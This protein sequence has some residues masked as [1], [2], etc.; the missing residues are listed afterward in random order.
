MSINGVSPG[1]AYH[2]S[3]PT[4][5]VAELATILRQARQAARETANAHTD[6]AVDCSM[7][8]AEHARDRAE[9]VRNSAYL[10]FAM[11]CGSALN[12]I[13]CAAMTGRSK[14]ANPDR[15]SSIARSSE[16][17]MGSVAKAVEA[18]DNAFG[19]G[20]QASHLEAKMEQDS[21]NEAQFNALRDRAQNRVDDLQDALA[22]ARQAYRE[23]NNGQ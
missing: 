3:S 11:S 2:G 5:V 12:S 19:F 17:I 6:A 10:N 1:A 14:D 23:L 21:A 22:D 13:G 18:G 9:A 7:D 4:D 8:R 15:T 20:Q 16:S